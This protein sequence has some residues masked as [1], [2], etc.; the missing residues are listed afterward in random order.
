MRKEVNNM[1]NKKV[2]I[3]VHEWNLEDYIV[4]DL[5][6]VITYDT[7]E[8]A[9][10][11]LNELKEQLIHE[12]DDEHNLNYETEETEATFSIW[13]KERYSCNHDRVFICESEVQ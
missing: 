9:K 10:E 13:E 3:V 2:Y 6:I 12:W 5:E 4:N 8:K 7:L 1:E 11:K